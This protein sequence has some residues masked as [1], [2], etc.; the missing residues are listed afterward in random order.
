MIKPEIEFSPISNQTNDQVFVF[1]VIHDL[2]HPTE[3]QSSAMT[4]LLNTTER[5]HAMFEN[6]FD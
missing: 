1:K 2:R 5:I 4:T 3:M 6:H